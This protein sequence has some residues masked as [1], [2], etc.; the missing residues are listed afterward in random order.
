MADQIRV[1][2]YKSF[3]DLKHQRDGRVVLVGSTLSETLSNISL[4]CKLPVKEVY[5]TTGGLV[6][7]LELL[8][9]G[10]ILIIGIPNDPPSP[11]SPQ[12]TDS[13]EERVSSS[14]TNIDPIS[15]SL[16]KCNTIPSSEASSRHDWV[17]LNVGGRIFATSRA[18]ITSDPS[19]MLARMFES[20]QPLLSQQV[21]VY[22]NRLVQCY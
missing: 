2:V 11:T 19:S 5:F 22:D 21:M 4:K 14:P 7:E 1:T 18:T 17:R 15:F 13:P 10:D 9:E 20:S 3:D 8:R 16:R 12:F 6:D